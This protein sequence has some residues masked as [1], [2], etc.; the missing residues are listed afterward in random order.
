MLGRAPVATPNL[1]KEDI[2][3]D[4]I[5]REA[6]GIREVGAAYGAAEGDVAEQ[7]GEGYVGAEV[8][9]VS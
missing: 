1:V 6:V 2:A 4:G 8:D 3:V 5:D 7:G 9:G